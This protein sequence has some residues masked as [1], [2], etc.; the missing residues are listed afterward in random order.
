MKIVT[1]LRNGVPLSSIADIYCNGNIINRD[2][3]PPYKVF[4]E[5]VTMNCAAGHYMVIELTEELIL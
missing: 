5:S 2:N 1:L 4:V 3:P